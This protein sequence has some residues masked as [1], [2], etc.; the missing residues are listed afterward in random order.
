MF[1]HL[2]GLG[3]FVGLALKGLTVVLYV[4]S[5]ILAFNKIVALEKL[6]CFFLY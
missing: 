1:G 3:H 6:G 2:I 5:T 4:G